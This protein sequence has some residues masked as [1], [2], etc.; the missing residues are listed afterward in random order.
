[1]TNLMALLKII[2]QLQPQIAQGRIILKSTRSITNPWIV[3]QNWFTPK[4]FALHIA[5]PPC[6]FYVVYIT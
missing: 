6:P 3:T 5:I 2:L 4:D 1:M